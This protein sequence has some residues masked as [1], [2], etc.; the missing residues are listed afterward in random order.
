[1]IRT[2][3]LAYQDIFSSIRNHTLGVRI[4]RWEDNNN[5]T[6][7][8]RGAFMNSNKFMTNMLKCIP[9]LPMAR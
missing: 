9:E 8:V 6:K 3:F 2:D 4:D 7:G 1:M 5:R